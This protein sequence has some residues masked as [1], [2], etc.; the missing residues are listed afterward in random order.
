MFSSVFCS[1]VPYSGLLIKTDVFYGVFDK[2]FHCPTAIKAQSLF[3]SYKDG[4]TW[5]TQDVTLIGDPRDFGPNINSCE[6]K[7]S[8]LQTKHPLLPLTSISVRLESSP[9]NAAQQNA[10]RAGTLKE[11]IKVPASTVSLLIP[12]EEAAKCRAFVTELLTRYGPN[13]F[14]VSEDD[15]FCDRCQLRTQSDADPIIC[16]E[17][18]KC[19]RGRH[20]E[21]FPRSLFPASSGLSGKRLQTFIQKNITHYC[22]SPHKPEEGGN[23]ASESRL[24]KPSATAAHSAPKHNF[25]PLTSIEQARQQNAVQVHLPRI[26]WSEGL[27]FNCKQLHVAL[28]RSGIPDAGD[29]LV[30]SQ[31]FENGALLGYIFG[32]LV[33][34]QRM[35]QL[36]QREKSDVADADEDE[37]AFRQEAVAGC[38]RVFDV[39]DVVSD[40]HDAYYMLVSKQ[41]PMGMINDPADHAR[42]GSQRG[43]GSKRTANAK[44]V[45]PPS[46]SVDSDGVLSWDA[47][48]V[49]A[50]ARINPGD[51]IFFDYSWTGDAWKAMWRARNRDAD[52]RAYKHELRVDWTPPEDIERSVRE[53]QAQESTA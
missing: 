33:S 2:L 43:N 36:T 18:R 22:C 39:S 10:I 49:R 5:K 44:V 50:T 19:L 28:Q 48:E 21:C 38:L 51:E 15:I 34:L 17:V 12:K 25:P 16:C 11:K 37:Q 24:R 3:Y 47:I 8:G 32:R 20:L 6:L 23:T 9:L 40:E 26:R 1:R 52:Q 13:F 46:V 4:G 29:G 41:C 7:S 53:A 31:V 45:F 42:K 30:A 35:Q 14:E 27:Q